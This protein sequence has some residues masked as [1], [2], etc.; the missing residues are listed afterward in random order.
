M[1]RLRWLRH[2]ALAG[3]ENTDP[4][5]NLSIGPGAR[6]AGH[7]PRRPE[8]EVQPTGARGVDEFC[9]ARVKRCAVAS[10]S[11]NGR[12][13]VSGN[14]TDGALESRLADLRGS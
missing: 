11:G 3:V 2:R 10:V 14:A 12:G 5:H 8:R 6:S 13:I 1:V 7:H 9:A 4:E